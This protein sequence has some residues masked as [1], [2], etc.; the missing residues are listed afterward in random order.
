MEEG[1][2]W[3]MAPNVDVSEKPRGSNAQRR[4]GAPQES[5]RRRQMVVVVAKRVS[6]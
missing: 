5:R 4:C 6:I 1:Q 3:A 2:L